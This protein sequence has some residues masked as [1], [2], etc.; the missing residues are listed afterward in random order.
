MNLQAKSTSKILIGLLVIFSNFTLAQLIHT[1]DS[2]YTTTARGNIVFSS[3]TIL[4]CSTAAGDTGAT[5]CVDARNG[6]N[7]ANNSYQMVNI[8]IDGD[9]STFNSSSA[10]FNL[11]AGASVLFAG[12]FWGGNSSSTSRNQTKFKVGAAAYNNLT[13]DIIYNNSSTYHAYDNVTTLVAAQAAGTTVSYTTANIQTSTSTGQYGGW[14]LVVVISDNTQVPRNMTVFNGYAIVKSGTN[15]NI[16][17]TVSG[18]LTPPAGAFSTQAGVLAYEG[19]KPYTGDNFQVNGIKLS[20]AVNPITNFF[21]SAITHLGAYVTTKNP[22][23][24]NQLG[25]DSKVVDVPYALG[26]IANGDTTADL[27]FQTTGDWYYPGVIT[28]AVEVFQPVLSDNFSKIATDLNGGDLIPGDIVEYTISFTNTGNDPATDVILT[29]SIPANTSYI[30]NSLEVVNDPN[31]AN[32]G[33]KTDVSGDDTAE[34]VGSNISFRLG[35][36]ANATNG[37]AIK[38]TETAVVK[39]K[40]MVNSNIAVDTISNQADIDYNG[41]TT[42]EAYHGVSDD[43]STG[44]SGDPTVST[45][46]LPTI[47]IKKTILG[48]SQNF[49]FTSADADL[50][51]VS[52][53]PVAN[54]TATSTTFSKG[55]ASYIISEDALV[56][57]RLTALSCTGDSDSGSNINLGSRTISIDLDP[58]EDIVCTFTNTELGKIIINKVTSPTGLADS[59][60]FSPSYGANFNLTDGTSNDSGYLLPN[61]YT[62]T[63]NIGAAWEL[64]SLSCVDPDS[65]SSTNLA[66]ATASLD[67]DSG[68]TISCTFT[69]DPLPNITITKT[70][71]VASIAETGANVNFTIQITNNTAESITLDSLNDSVFGNLNGLGDC[72]TGGAIAGS[73]TYSCSFSQALSGTVASPHNNT[74]TAQV[75]DNEANTDSDSNSATVNYTDVLPDITVNKT[76]VET[77]IDEPG[78][79]VT[80][81]FEVV[82]NTAE[83]IT[84]QSLDDNRFGDLNGQGTCTT[85]QILAGNASY[86]CSSTQ[87]ILG[88]IG[89]SH[90]NIVTAEVED[91]EANSLLKT[92]S[93]TIPF[94]G[95][96]LTK[97]ACNTSTTNCSLLT[98][99]SSSVIADPGE[100][101]EYRIKYKRIGSFAYSFNL[102]DTIPAGTT[103]SDS[104]YV[105]NTEV[106]LVCPDASIVHLERSGALAINIDLATE[107]TLNTQLV[108]G[109]ITEVL[110]A[111]EEGTFNFRVLVP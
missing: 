88:N 37:G 60:S 69:N 33:A 59:F 43:P 35:T 85:P 94:Y 5:S 16:T 9:A 42:G 3:N 4:T 81:N 78:G 50:D 104:S 89:D 79:N 87:N 108:G 28:F 19:D 47:T 74:A 21:N 66:T 38:P 8:D 82:N 29:D 76:S 67:L 97:S 15:D 12:L 36:G 22:N 32:I 109:I 49:T 30:A 70:P 51:A 98:N 24:Q 34:I 44:T 48:S 25:Y 14:T 41:Q 105:G 10:D 80:Y 6:A 96:E 101:I 39:F 61:S 55:A 7:S 11:P 72:V 13:A 110:L 62:V 102:D 64:T 86:S 18:F 57:W 46:L 95:I 26:A 23:Y 53:T 54:G 84:L 56:D 91:D 65:G 45:V 2:V 20:D 93:L 103:I 83:T 100:I 77:S 52:L 90:T 71:S 99:F 40:V 107:C 106:E 63:E 75:S 31:A 17:T 111:N 1:F 68:E 58:G 73:S 27:T 92:D